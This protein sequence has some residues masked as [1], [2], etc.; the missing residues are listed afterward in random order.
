MSTHKGKEKILDHDQ[1]RT[2]VG[3]VALLKHEGCR[4][5]YSPTQILISSG[6]VK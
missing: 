2:V 5:F 6:N 1:N 3:K 4:N